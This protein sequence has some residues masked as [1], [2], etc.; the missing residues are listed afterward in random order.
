MIVVG[1]AVLLYALEPFQTFPQGVQPGSQTGA[2]TTNGSSL[3]P[4]SVTSASGPPSSPV[5]GNGTA[6][7]TYPPEYA[8]LQN[9]TLAL[10]NRDRARYGLSPVAI[11]SVDSGQQHADSM[12]YFGYFSHWDTQGY[13]P[14]MRYTLLNGS[15]AV[16]ENVA[17]EFSTIPTFRGPSAVEL[18]LSKLEYEMMYNDSACCNNGHMHNILDPLHNRVSIGVAYNSTRVYLVE[19]FENVYI[20][21][22][23]PF[24][25][26]GGTI[27]LFGTSSL[28]LSGVQVLVFYDEYPH[29]LTSAQLGAAP[30]SGSYDQGNF[31][32][33]VVPSCVLSCLTY[34]G[35]VTTTAQTWNVT[36]NSI[37]IRFQISK[38]VQA[39]GRG[40]YTVY[41]EEHGRTTPEVIFDMS[42]FAG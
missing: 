12:L 29:T 23:R 40:V 42:F 33:G 28:D 17:Y 37:G 5:I 20:S 19:D 13:K 41:L 26:Q 30:Y 11:S 6:I 7:V 25:S 1:G 32:G 9:Y 31:T 36:A 15:G 14:Y 27:S 2:S 38:F 8:I 22:T 3:T 18:V 16:E 21:F 4:S 34:Q 24:T 10:I 35:Y 39:Y